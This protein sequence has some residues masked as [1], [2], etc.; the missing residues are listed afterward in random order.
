VSLLISEPDRQRIERAIAA[1]EQRSAVEVVVV[2]SA[3]SDSYAEPRALLAGALLIGAGL[4]AYEL[5]PPLPGAWIF[6]GQALVAPLLWWLAGRR[7]VL[8]LL[9]AGPWAAGAVHARAQQIF[10]ERGLT[11]THQRSGVLIAIS[12]LE[13]RVEILADRGIHARVGDAGWQAEVQR[14][15]RSIRAGRAADGV[16]EIIDELAERLSGP[17]PPLPEDRNELP[18]AVRRA[19]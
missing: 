8:R 10:V 11:E 4:L 17:L 19:L 6:A 3:A 14:L 15:T 2:D 1:A 13:R 5:G 7:S 9:V 18:D 12:E 16:I